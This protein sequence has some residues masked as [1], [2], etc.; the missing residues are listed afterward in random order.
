MS[1]SAEKTALY[2]SLS[3]L[4]T[5]GLPFYPAF[6]AFY[7]GVALPG[8]CTPM[9]RD[10][11]PEIGF[12][13]TEDFRSHLEAAIALNH[14]VHDGV[15]IFGRQTPADTYICKGWSYRILAEGRGLHPERNRGSAYNSAIAFSNEHSVDLV[16]LMTPGQVE[17]FVSGHRVDAQGQ[18]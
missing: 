10:P 15:V 2:R 6:L 3:D 18:L 13:F 9:P 12:S 17:F 14:S 5:A 16:A 4:A 8:G 11:Y 7:T 1:L